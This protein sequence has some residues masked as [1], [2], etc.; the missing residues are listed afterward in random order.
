MTHIHNRTLI[1]IKIIQQ[2]NLKLYNEV[3]LKE[4]IIK[5]FQK[6]ETTNTTEANILQTRK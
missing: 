2:S 3:V 4:S 1:S 6:I 5:L